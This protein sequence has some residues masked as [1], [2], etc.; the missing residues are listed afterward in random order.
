MK[1]INL[2][3]VTMK[4]EDQEGE[5]Y[6]R[7]IARYFFLKRGAPFLLSPRE[8]DLIARWE[9][10]S[11]PL[12]VVFEGIDRSLEKARKKK[13]PY[14]AFSLLLCDGEVQR[15]YAQYRERLVG[16]TRLSVAP[17]KH[18]NILQAINYFLQNLP[19]NLS[20]LKPILIEALEVIKTGDKKD[21]EGKLEALEEAMDREMVA[22]ARA[23]ER[24]EVKAW[25]EKE[26]PGI[27]G[28]EKEEIFKTALVKLM[29]EKYR[30]PHLLTC[31]Y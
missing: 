29:R 30:I 7:A 27:G 14:S 6:Y 15:A 23:E 19:S 17:D 3:R 5:Y 16:K 11:I 4:K 12:M 31:Y 1:E 9:A 22:A 25:I 26:F 8:L 10:A 18:E 21:R 28:A 24:K 2:E 13:R 20:N